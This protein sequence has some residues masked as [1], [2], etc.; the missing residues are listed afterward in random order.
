MEFFIIFTV[1]KLHFTEADDGNTVCQKARFSQLRTQLN[2][3]PH[4]NFEHFTRRGNKP[5]EATVNWPPG[6][7]PPLTK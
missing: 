4:L 5:K 7:Q 2:G 1:M 3:C 6:K